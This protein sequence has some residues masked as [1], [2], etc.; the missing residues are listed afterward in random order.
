MT[1]NATAWYVESKLKT[2]SD[3]HY[4]M[5]T[6]F[7]SIIIQEF[8]GQKLLGDDGIDNEFDLGLLRATHHMERLKKAYNNLD[9]R[10]IKDEA[11]FDETD[12][13]IILKGVTV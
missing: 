1:K 12:R 10:I 6:C 8:N 4:E 3:D 5:D 9:F 2:E 11:M 13:E 7:T